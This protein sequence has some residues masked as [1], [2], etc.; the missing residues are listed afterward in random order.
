MIFTELEPVPRCAI[1]S[2]TPNT[3]PDS[4]SVTP[5]SVIQMVKRMC[6]ICNPIHIEA[7]CTSRHPLRDVSCVHVPKKSRRTSEGGVE[8]VDLGRSGQVD[9][10][11]SSGPPNASRDSLVLS[12][13]STKRP[14]RTPGLTCSISIYAQTQHHDTHP[15][16]DL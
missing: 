14:P 2:I 11:V 7:I 4:K 5:R 3:T 6:T 1:A 16:V 12:P 13:K 8:S 10:W 15:V 9:C